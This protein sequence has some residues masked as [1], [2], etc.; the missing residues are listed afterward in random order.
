MNMKTKIITYSLLFAAVIVVSSCSKSNTVI[1][2]ATNSVFTASLDGASE[3]PPNAST[4]TGSAT[5][6]YN[7]TTK[8]LS[9]SITFSG[10]TTATTA[11]HI[12][13][14]AVGVAG[15]VV[16]SIEASGPFT[17]P[18]NYTSPVLT[19]AQFAD[20]VGG[21]YYVNIHTVAFPNGEIRGQLMLQGSSGG[22]GSGTGGGGGGGG[23]Y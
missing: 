4:A 10:F 17:S 1:P 15:N 12:H 9:G 14:G 18:I 19:S 16:F 5:F 23:G 3:T 22:Y 11:A 13:M 20:L 7:P 6:T 2:M 8:M 21:L